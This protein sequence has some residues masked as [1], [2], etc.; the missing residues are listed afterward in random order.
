MGCMKGAG[1]HGCGQVGVQR[2]CAWLGAH[3]NGQEHRNAR[4]LLC[5]QLL[6]V[7]ASQHRWRPVFV[8]MFRDKPQ[9]QRDTSKSSPARL[10]SY[11]DTAHEATCR[12]GSKFSKYPDVGQ[13]IQ[14]LSIVAAPLSV[15]TTNSGGE[16]CCFG[17]FVGRTAVSNG[18]PYDL[19]ER[20]RR[21][22]TLTPRSWKK[23]AHVCYAQGVSAI[24]KDALFL[25]QSCCGRMYAYFMPTQKPRA[26]ERP[27]DPSSAMH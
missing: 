26:A 9:T 18:F 2:W 11:P 10:R 17:R 8:L 3:E 1:C 23:A 16:L 6:I 21:S 22:Q 25:F 13:N 15:F 27:S 14:S 20:L 7:G 19:V 4:A 5:V 12:L 24:G